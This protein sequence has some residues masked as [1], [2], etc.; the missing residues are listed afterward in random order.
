[1]DY[2]ESG[3]V[4]VYD[5]SKVIDPENV[6]LHGGFLVKTLVLSIAPYLRGQM[7]D[8]EIRSYAPPLHVGEPLF[9]FGVGRVLR[10]EHSSVKA[11]DHVYGIL[12]HEEYSLHKELG[13]LRIIDNKFNLPWSVYVGAAGMPGMTAFM[14]WHLYSDAE[15][16]ET[17]FV[18]SGAGPVGLMVIQLAKRDHLKVIA[19][20]GSDEKV[21]FMKEIGAD[22]AFNYKT[23]DT[24]AILAKEGPIDIYWDNVGGETLEAALEAASVNARFIECGMV[25]GYK[26]G[27]APVKSLLNIVAKSITLYG[28]IVFRLQKQ[29][30]QLVDKFYETILPLLASGE[31]KY[32]EEI[33][34]GLDKVGDVFLGIQKG[35]NKGK[36]V[37]WLADE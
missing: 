34:R 2:P 12:T 27:E 36:A 20:A 9:S 19:S 16:G 3:E 17:A 24:R 23:T 13:E 25:S 21:A 28:F 26:E 14:A 22:V 33:T 6:P 1:M 11:G 15:K 7:C 10:S 29:H 31:L 5:T 37:I 8:P 18:A 4:L 32:K 35:T 30:P